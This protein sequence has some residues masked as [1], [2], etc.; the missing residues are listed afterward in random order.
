MKLIKI[1]LLF[2][3]GEETQSGPH[4]LYMRYGVRSEENKDI[5]INQSHL[6]I[7]LGE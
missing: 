2:Y 4:C 7:K 1:L 3:K 5:V 6:A